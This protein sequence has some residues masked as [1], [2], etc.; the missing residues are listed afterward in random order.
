MEFEIDISTGRSTLELGSLRITDLKIRAKTSEVQIFLPAHDG[1]ITVH[2]QARTAYVTVHVPPDVAA[3]IHGD[4]DP[5]SDEIDLARFPVVKGVVAY[6]S[7]H[8][9]TTSKRV[10]IRM[11]NA[12]SSVKIVQAQY[13]NVISPMVAGT[14]QWFHTVP[15]L[16]VQSLVPSQ[17]IQMSE[18]CI[19]RKSFE[20]TVNGG[21]LAPVLF[22]ACVQP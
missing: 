11:D 14:V 20:I 22:F 3:Y 1:H 13:I 10:D 16:S 7:E 9:E 17:K 12:T 19:D 2:I 8:Y 4:R 15:A 18:L 21:N 5:V 6:R